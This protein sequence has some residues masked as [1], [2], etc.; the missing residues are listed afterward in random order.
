MLLTAATDEQGG[1]SVPEDKPLGRGTLR[2]A[3][4]GHSVHI[5]VP[6]GYA[7]DHGIGRLQYL[8]VHEFG[9]VLGFSHEQDRVDNSDQIEATCNPP[10][11]ESGA[12][13]SRY[14]NQSVMHYC[15]D[16]GNSSGRLSAI[17]VRSVQ[18]IYGIRTNGGADFNGDGF[19]DVLIYNA[20]TGYSEIRYGR[21][22]AGLDFV[23]ASQTTWATGL[24][25]VPGDYDGDG[26]V[27]VILYSA[28]TGAAEVR[29]GQTAAAGLLADYRAQTNWGGNLK[30]I[31]GDFGGDGYMDVLKQDSV[32]GYTSIEKGRTFIGFAPIV[33]AN[34][35]WNL[36]F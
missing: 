6:P 36:G 27:D 16:G 34:P 18:H 28:G 22:A 17:D 15:N 1:G 30:L 7:T 8:A 24:K 13:W 21:A 26:H 4:E 32:S 9:H 35:V 20:A 10:G 23:P 5:A 19:S 12:F 31:P 2:L 11:V 14:D 25:V 3:T 33:Q 29:F